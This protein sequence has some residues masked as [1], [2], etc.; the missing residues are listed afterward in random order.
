[1]IIPVKDNTWDRDFQMSLILKYMAI[2]SQNIIKQYYTN[3]D[4]LTME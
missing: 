3:I 1:M 4:W 2:L